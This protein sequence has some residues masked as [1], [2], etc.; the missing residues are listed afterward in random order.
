[1]Q[2][3]EEI[4]TP[5][6]P[7]PSNS[8]SKS[9]P[10][11]RVKSWTFWGWNGCSFILIDLHATAL[12]YLKIENCEIWWID[13][14]CL[15]YLNRFVTN[16]KLRSF[17]RWWHSVFEMKCSACIVGIILQQSFIWKYYLSV[18]VQVCWC[19][20]VRFVSNCCMMSSHVHLLL[21]LFMLVINTVVTTKIMYF[22]LYFVLVY[23]LVM[24][25]NYPNVL[26]KYLNME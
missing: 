5:S 19:K 6:G 18:N 25:C 1:M 8:F 7:K 14:V 17:N 11:V 20:Y 2:V 21:I 12:K 9:V 10:A 3:F 22:T 4:K 26:I 24:I 23:M 15:E 13:A 16:M